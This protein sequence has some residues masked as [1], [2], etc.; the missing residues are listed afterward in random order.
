MRRKR[1]VGGDMGPLTTGTSTCKCRGTD[2]WDSMLGLGVESDPKSG[3]GGAEIR[4]AG[5]NAI[6]KKTGH[7]LPGCTCGWRVERW[8]LG[9]LR[10][11]NHVSFTLRQSLPWQ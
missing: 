11:G 5:F 3:W 7:D 10:E 1:G 4:E 9:A 6:Q 2:V 8:L